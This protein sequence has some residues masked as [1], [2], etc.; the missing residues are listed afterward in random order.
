MIEK[1]KNPKIVNDFKKFR[2]S[3]KV[4]ESDT[5][6]ENKYCKSIDAKRRYIN[7]LVKTKEG[8]KRINEASEKANK[9]IEE[10]LKF[11]TKKYLYFDF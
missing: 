9:Q 10:Y 3:T 2:N 1:S 6:V 5:F 8:Y 4:Y 7:P 11:K